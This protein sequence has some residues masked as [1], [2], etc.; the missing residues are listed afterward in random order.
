MRISHYFPL[1]CI[2]STLLLVACS[3]PKTYSY[4]MLHPQAIKTE[5]QA[6]Q[7]SALASDECAAAVKAAQD[8]NNLL[9]QAS[10]NGQLF[11]AGLIN[12]QAAMVQAQQAV[13]AAKNAVMAIEDSSNTAAIAATQAKLQ[14]AQ[15]AYEAAQFK[16]QTKRAAL[17]L[18]GP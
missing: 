12:D 18:M 11:G 16:V 2:A 5:L 1:A 6:C 9:A 10:S 17:A 15:T 14:Q 13:D 8:V 4:F 3:E 7:G